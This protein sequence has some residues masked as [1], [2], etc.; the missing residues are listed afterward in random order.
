MCKNLM[1]DELI[2]YESVSGVRLCESGVIGG[3][4][5][6]EWELW[7]RERC[8]IVWEWC[9]WVVWQVTEKRVSRFESVCG[10]VACL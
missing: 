2:K 8:E 3:K 5:E 9:E 4:S 1:K 7:E 10:V 6:I